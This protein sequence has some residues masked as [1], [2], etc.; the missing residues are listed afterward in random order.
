MTFTTLP[1]IDQVER[2]AS[3]MAA[4]FAMA[5]LVAA[6][7]AVLNYRSRVQQ[8]YGYWPLEDEELWVYSV[9]IRMVILLGLVR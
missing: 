8:A 3:F 5:T 4:G 2:V 1:G 6:V 7:I 9:S